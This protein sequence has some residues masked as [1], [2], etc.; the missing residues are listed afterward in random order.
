MLS[1]LEL[2]C[3]DVRDSLSALSILAMLLDMRFTMVRG[4]ES[5]SGER[6]SVLLS[7][8]TGA[9]GTSDLVWARGFASFTS[10]GAISLVW[11]RGFAALTGRRAACT[12][13]VCA[14]VRAS[15]TASPP[16]RQPV[17]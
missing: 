7:L 15:A 9:A 10:D 6:A 13:C 5:L 2:P 4:V 8:G 14:C 17:A 3:D 16:A 11:A 1:S 12:G